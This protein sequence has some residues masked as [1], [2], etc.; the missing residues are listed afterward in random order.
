MP[1]KETLPG[2]C[3]MLLLCSLLKRQTLLNLYNFSSISGLFFHFD[4]IHFTFYHNF[5]VMKR[6]SFT[7]FLTCIFTSFAQLRYL[8]RALGF[9]LVNII[10]RPKRISEP[11][12]SAFQSSFWIAASRCAIHIPP[13]I[14]FGFLFYL[15][16]NIIY[17]GPGFSKKKDDAFYLALFQGQ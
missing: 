9:E 17:V 2:I 13:C 1:F 11:P 10:V 3:P 8:L 5:Y 14:V 7:T 16:Y 15:T 12:K 6:P 4:A